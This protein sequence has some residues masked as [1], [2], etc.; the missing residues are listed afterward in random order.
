MV[1]FQSYVMCLLGYEFHILDNAFLA[2]RPGF[3]IKELDFLRQVY[4]ER[5]NLLLK[6]KLVREYQSLYGQ[7]NECNSAW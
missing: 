5:T 4:I 1:K 2:H 6:N 7:R 3:K